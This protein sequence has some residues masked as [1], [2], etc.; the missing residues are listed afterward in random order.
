VANCFSATINGE[1]LEMRM[2]PLVANKLLRPAAERTLKG[3]KSGAVIIPGNPARFRYT[4]D[5]VSP[6]L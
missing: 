2:H 5:A 6:D 3:D 1:F 4:G